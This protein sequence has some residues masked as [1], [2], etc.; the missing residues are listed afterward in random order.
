MGSRSKSLSAGLI[1]L[2]FGCISM[3]RAVEI[4][5]YPSGTSYYNTNNT[6]SNSWSAWSS[7]WGTRD[8]NTGWDYVGQVGNS[9][10]G[11]GVYL[12]NGWVI[13]AG[14]VG[15][16]DFTLGTNTYLTTGFSYADFTY[17]YLGTTEYADLNLFRISSVSTTGNSLLPTNNLSLVPAYNSAGNS[18]V[19][20]GYGDA[21]VGRQKSWGIN[22]VTANNL[23]VPLGGTPYTSVD[24]QTAYGPGAY[25]ITNSAVLVTGDSG[26]GGFA[27][28][29]SRWYLVGLNE[30]VSG[31]NSYF[32]NL[33]YYSSQITA[34]M[35]SVPEPGTWV[36]IGIG[37]PLTW[38]FA[39]RSRKA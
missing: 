37:L 11:S 26:G 1:L 22:T 16:S 17:N 7:G 20:I 6:I 35:A 18:L 38:V 10:Q 5:P 29:G 3:V 25:G 23:L 19:M 36:L 2:M 27:F 34:V 8:T 21:S 15:A 9:S 13:T 39:K 28:D 24:F 32:V 4:I 31:N 14:H 12:G 30:A 33:G